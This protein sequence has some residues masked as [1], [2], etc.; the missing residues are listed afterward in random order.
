MTPNWFNIYV[1]PLSWN[2]QRKNKLE[3]N[4]EIIARTK[5]IDQDVWNFY[6]FKKVFYG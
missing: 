1:K 5:D 3:L 4:E 6:L 2:T